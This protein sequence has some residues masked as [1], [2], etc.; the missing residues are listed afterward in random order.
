M[1]DKDK[2]IADELKATR[3][4]QPFDTRHLPIVAAVAVTH[5]DYTAIAA[6]AAFE[7]AI[8]DPYTAI[9]AHITS[10]A[11]AEQAETVTKALGRRCGSSPAFGVPYGEPMYPHLRKLKQWIG[12]AM[13]AADQDG[14]RSNTAV[15][16]SGPYG[17]H[18]GTHVITRDYVQKIYDELVELSNRVPS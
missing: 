1:T 14:A 6:D 18:Q 11:I 5:E 4:K 12:S 9:A 8:K 3:Q 10:P 16:I 17:R 7:Q 2:V 15:L 13:A